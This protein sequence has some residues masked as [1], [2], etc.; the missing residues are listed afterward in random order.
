MPKGVYERTPDNI[1]KPRVYPPEIV[2]LACDMYL[3]GMTVAEIRAEFPRGYRVQTIL[4]RHLS[5]RRAQAK[6]DQRGQQNTAWK[7]DSVSYDGAHMRLYELRG[8]ARSHP[9]VDCGETADEWSYGGTCPTEQISD[10]GC[11]Y[12]THPEHYRP[13]CRSCHRALDARIRRSRQEEAA[14][15]A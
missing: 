7:G 6:R 11:R 12:C 3:S 13:R 9:C 1:R 4:E 10:R 5:V 8:P 15:H 2:A 14:P